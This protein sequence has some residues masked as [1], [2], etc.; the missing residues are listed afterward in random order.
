MAWRATGGARR[1]PRGT[2]GSGPSRRHCRAQRAQPYAYQQAA[3][4]I[5][6]AADMSREA[7]AG[8]QALG[9]TGRQ[10]DPYLTAYTN[11]T[12]MR[13]FNKLWRH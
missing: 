6:R 1:Y 2:T 11:P 8:Y 7:K 13:W 9:G 5:G 10:F 4:D 12:K 3:A